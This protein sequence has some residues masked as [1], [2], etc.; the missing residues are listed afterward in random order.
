MF[1]T[2]TAK[3]LGGVAILFGTLYLVNGALPGVGTTLALALLVLIF[4]RKEWAVSTVT[5]LLGWPGRVTA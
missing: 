2:E 3:Y 5:R 4:L 1:T